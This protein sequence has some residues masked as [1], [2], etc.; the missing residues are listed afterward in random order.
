MVSESKFKI[1]D[2]VRYVGDPLYSEAR[3]PSK[4]GIIEDVSGGAQD[5]LAYVKW[6]A[7]TRIIGYYQFRLALAAPTGEF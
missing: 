1:G 7:E 5:A 4:V 2:R 6:E 3:I